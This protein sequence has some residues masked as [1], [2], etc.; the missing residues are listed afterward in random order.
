[1]I[2]ALT[3][4]PGSAQEPILTINMP[5]PPALFTQIPQTIINMILKDYLLNPTYGWKAII[6]FSLTCKSHQKFANTVILRINT[7]SVQSIAD[8]RKL[9]CVSNP[10]PLKRLNI[11]NRNLR[12]TKKIINKAK[13]LPFLSEIRIANFFNRKK[14]LR[15]Q[16]MSINQK[17]IKAYPSCLQMSPFKNRR[18]FLLNVLKDRGST[19]KYTSIWSRDCY[20]IVQAAVS[21]QG[22]ALEFASPGLKGTFLIAKRAVQNNGLALRFASPG[23]RNH[24][25]IILSAVRNNGLALQFVSQKFRN[26]QNIT[27][28]AVEANGLALQFVGE[29]LQTNKKIILAALKQNIQALQYVNK[30]ALKD[31]DIQTFITLNKDTQS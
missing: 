6:A 7:A 2:Q 20:T 17:I 5:P 23:L 9:F 30:E 16:N 31:E 10:L 13:A 28:T 18:V 29:H 8:I 21:N 4:F 27:L 14:I 1:M 22:C 12:I 15:S 11:E 24:Y 19:L 25:N 26:H 3:P